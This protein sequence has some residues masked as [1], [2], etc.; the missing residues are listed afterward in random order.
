MAGKRDGHILIG[1][2]GI[3]PR[4]NSEQ[5]GIDDDAYPAATSH[6]MVPE[7]YTKGPKWSSSTAATYQ[8]PVNDA[9]MDPALPHAY[10]TSSLHDALLITGVHGLTGFA[11]HE[12][13]LVMVLVHTHHTTF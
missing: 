1:T 11:P 12:P 3:D 5:F 13:S 9:P 2:V 7:F 4:L 8:S 10:S 6:P